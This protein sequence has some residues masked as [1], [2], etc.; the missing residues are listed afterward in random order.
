MMIFHFKMISGD[1]GIVERHKYL[2]ISCA[3]V[4]SAGISLDLFKCPTTTSLTYYSV[5]GEGTVSRVCPDDPRTYQVCGIIMSSQGWYGSNPATPEVF[6]LAHEISV[7]ICGDTLKHINNV[8]DKMSYRISGGGALLTN[9]S[10][11]YTV[12][13]NGLCDNGGCTDEIF[14]D[15]FQYALRCDIRDKFKSMFGLK[16]LSARFICDK[17]VH[18]NGGEDE[19]G[20]AKYDREIKFR[21]NLF[22]SAIDFK[23]H[24]ATTMPCSSLQ[25]N[26]VSSYFI[27]LQNFSRCSALADLRW[28]YD[29]SVFAVTH[30]L[31][32]ILPLCHY[33]IDQTNCSDPARGVIPCL[34]NGYPST[35]SKFATCVQT[36]GLCDDQFD[37]LCVETAPSCKI[38]K[39]QLCNEIRDCSDGSDED[40]Q[41]C[42]TQTVSSCYRRYRHEEAL[43]IPIAWLQDGF[44]DCLNGDD[45]RNI[46]AKCGNDK[47]S[48][49]VPENYVCEDVY[50]CSPVSSD[51]VLFENLCNGQDSC[52]HGRICSEARS[53]KFAFTNPASM[54]G[55]EFLL[56]CVTGVSKSLGYLISRC[57]MK[58]FTPFPILGLD[59]PPSI[60]LP[61]KV[62]NCQNLFGKV[63][64]YLSCSKKCGDQVRCPLKPPSYDACPVEMNYEDKKFTAVLG[65]QKVLTFL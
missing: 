16:Y 6:W 59:E 18:C 14:C 35:V 20:C 40:N 4:R 39:H 12:V 26:H 57:A 56:H 55:S 31:S 23:I 58:D 32:S 41:I 21:Y 44:K 46:W 64:V 10:N 15:G 52:G 36:P 2:K 34:I 54:K 33:Y 25:Y 50:I 11:P 19:L 45:E 37:D 30:R 38:H 7:P 28:E 17:I 24:E 65:K 13:C 22:D 62:P 53:S 60:M 8:A 29:S 5:I 3:S 42:R 49:N 63:Y 9:V 48:H 1:C 51:F 43:S 61:E 47:F 27:L